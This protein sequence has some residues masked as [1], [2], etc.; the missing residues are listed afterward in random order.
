ML[1]QPKTLYLTIVLCSI[2]S[3]IQGWDQEGANG[4]NLSFP[5]VMGIDDSCSTDPLFCRRNSWI[6]G[7]INSAPYFSIAL[8]AAWPSDPLN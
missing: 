6:V 8:F 5:V 3:A 7:V 1:S 4:A 2:A